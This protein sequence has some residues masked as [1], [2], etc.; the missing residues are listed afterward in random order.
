MPVQTKDRKSGLFFFAF[1]FLLTLTACSNDAPKTTPGLAW[2][3]TQHEDLK[4][5]YFI[6]KF[7]V[8]NH[9][10][11]WDHG[12]YLRAYVDMYEATHDFACSKS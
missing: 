12:A 3:L 8:D 9:P 2:F 7:G 4:S 1:F 6:G 10:S 11:G 5:S